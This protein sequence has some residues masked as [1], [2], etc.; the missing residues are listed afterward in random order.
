MAF[1]W[2]NLSA[3][4]S[5]LDVVED[6]SE[7]QGICSTLVNEFPWAR[8]R[9]VSSIT[10]EPQLTKGLYAAGDR[11]GHR[12]GTITL[13]G[14]IPSKAKPSDEIWAL[15]GSEWPFVLRRRYRENDDEAITGNKFS[16]IRSRWWWPWNSGAA[17]RTRTAAY[18]LLGDAYVH[19]LM[20]GE[21]GAE[22]TQNLE[23]III[24]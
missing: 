9:S 6:V 17:D 8:G 12:G 19:G 3:C 14:L 15:Q 5:H 16:N 21:L 7:S 13:S 10:L 20:N 11:Q 24:S 1:R 23:E 2:N 4:V 18:E 22:I